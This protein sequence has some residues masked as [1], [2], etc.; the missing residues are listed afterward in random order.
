MDSDRQELSG[1]QYSAQGQLQSPSGH[2]LL[3]PGTVDM[4]PQR[5]EG[6]INGRSV[7]LGL[8]GARLGCGSLSQPSLCLM[9]AGDLRAD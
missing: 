8:A 4:G 6:K 7:S 2:V 1:P 9:K 5:K 3:K